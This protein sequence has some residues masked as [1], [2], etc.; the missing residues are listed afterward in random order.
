MP[1]Q[2][3][4]RTRTQQSDT[5]NKHT[6]RAGKI[7]PPGS[8]EAE[9]KPTTNT[10]AKATPSLQNSRPFRGG[11]LGGLSGRGGGGGGSLCVLLLPASLQLFQGIPP[12]FFSV[13]EHKVGRLH[14]KKQTIHTN[15]SALGI[16]RTVQYM[17]AGGCEQRAPM[18]CRTTNMINPK[19]SIWRVQ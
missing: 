18:S 14:E 16:I 9:R 13:V 15:A 19:P 2:R 1:T 6:I 12:Q 5:Y 4:E 17:K 10:P 7:T 11:R 8:S 3:R